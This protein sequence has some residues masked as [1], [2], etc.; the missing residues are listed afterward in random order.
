MNRSGA[1]SQLAVGVQ[2]NAG[3][4][5]VP[6]AAS[7]DGGDSTE[8]TTS[9]PHGYSS[10][11]A[12][13]LSGFSV[14]AY[15]VTNESITTVSDSTHFTV[16]ISYDDNVSGLVTGGE[17]IF[18]SEAAA[19]DRILL[20]SGSPKKTFEQIQEE[21]LTGNV[22]RGAP[23]QGLATSTDT[24]DCTVP[25]TLKDGDDFISAD[26]LIAAFM[27]ENNY[28]SPWNEIVFNDLSVYALTLAYIFGTATAGRLK[29]FTG[30]IPTSMELS[31]EL[32]GKLS[33]SFDYVGYDAGDTD[34][35]NSKSDIDSIPHIGHTNAMGHY[36]EF[37][38][39]DDL[40]D[41][42]A[43]SDR[44]KLILYPYN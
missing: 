37:F 5:S 17:S 16:E 22:G 31:C 40:S 36:M 24:L 23:E 1:A 12:V 33:A 21:A 14:S 11:D 28:S 30:A 35:T 18:S 20:T 10:G 42:L 6:S 9:I 34:G 41:S 44:L 3:S 39:T 15:N 32:S 2:G 29:V 13:T 26:A 43:N 4:I 19:T 7:A 8:F 27:G 38:L 25:F